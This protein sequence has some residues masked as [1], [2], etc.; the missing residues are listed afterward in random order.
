MKSKKLLK[1]LGYIFIAIVGIV[2]VIFSGQ[3]GKFYGRKVATDYSE[4]RKDGSIEK[5]M[6]STAEDIRKTLPREVGGFMMYDVL[7]IDKTLTYFYRLPQK[8][9]EIDDDWFMRDQAPALKHNVCKHQSMSN[10]I[11]KHG[12]TYGYVYFSQEGLLIGEIEIGRKV[13]NY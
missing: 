8:L 13:C 6:E 3:L 2:F 1:G 9:T 5:L 7:A 11:K 4:G 12:V 10:T